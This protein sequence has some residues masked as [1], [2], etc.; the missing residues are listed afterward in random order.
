MGYTKRVKTGDTYKYL[1]DLI[2][3]KGRK[4]PMCYVNIP[5]DII[6]HLKLYGKKKAY[7]YVNGNKIVVEPLD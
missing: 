7:V 5:C 1:R 3:R 6:E 2:W 4:N